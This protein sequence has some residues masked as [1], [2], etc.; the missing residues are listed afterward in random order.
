MPC[1]PFLHTSDLSVYFEILKTY[2]EV[3]LNTANGS[4]RLCEFCLLIPSHFTQPLAKKC[5]LQIVM[6]MYPKLNRRSML[7]PVLP[8]ALDALLNMCTAFNASSEILGLVLE[9]MTVVLSVSER[10]LSDM[11][12]Y[13]LENPD[14]HK[15]S[16]WLHYSNIPNSK[17]GAR[18]SHPHALE[19]ACKVHVLSN[20]NGP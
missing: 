8:A 6:R 18:L 11:L 19:P 20:E 13:R 3:L 7:R 9:N 12:R 10:F 14:S 17:R 15:S 2:V 16:Q 4:D 5:A 1:L